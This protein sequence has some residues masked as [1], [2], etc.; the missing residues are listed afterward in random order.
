M[1][2]LVEACHHS[3]ATLLDLIQKPETLIYTLSSRYV[4]PLMRLNQI[5]FSEKLVRSI[6]AP[7]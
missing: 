6:H 1:I 4:I 7:G 2:G 3:G 5:R